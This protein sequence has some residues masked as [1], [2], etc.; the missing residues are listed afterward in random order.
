[1]SSGS[2]QHTKKWMILEQAPSSGCAV[3]WIC[4]ARTCV[5]LTCM[6]CHWHTCAAASAAKSGMKPL[7]SNAAAE[8]L[9]T[10]ADLSEAHLEEAELI[11]QAVCLLDAHLHQLLPG[12]DEG[13]EL[14]DLIGPGLQHT[15]M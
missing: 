2:W 1:M 12:A 6:P 7:K 4:G 10:G 14:Q 3:G 9:L 11:G 13:T 8:V 15:E 5:M